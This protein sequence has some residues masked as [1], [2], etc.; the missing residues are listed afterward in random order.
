MNNLL[1]I[2]RRLRG[3]GG[4]P[5]DQKQTH[6]S[7]RPYMLEEAYEAVD[8]I[9]S[10]DTEHMVEELGD[11]LLQ[12]AFHSVIAEETARFS[13]GDIEQSIIDKLIRRHPHVF[14]DVTVKDADE[15]VS[16]WQAIKEREK[17]KTEGE[18]GRRL[19]LSLVYPEEFEGSNEG[20][21]DRV[22][23]HLPALMLALETSKKYQWSSENA[24]EATSSEGLG[25]ELLSLVN[26]AKELGINPEIALREAVDRRVEHESGD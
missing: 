20:E 14:G 22:H 11:V 4:C 6:Q 10:D 13:Y 19:V 5:W 12:I 17:G 9:S 8:A 18:K 16:N 2:M 26:R 3:P 24:I 23:R 21:K 15:V 1:A 7:L 25:E